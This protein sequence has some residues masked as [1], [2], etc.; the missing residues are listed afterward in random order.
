[1]ERARPSRLPLKSGKN[2]RRT[3]APRKRSARPERASR[4]ERPTR[5]RESDET[6]PP[7]FAVRRE[8]LAIGLLVA[9]L[10]T[11][12]ALAS[13]DPR[14]GDN[15]IGPAG[16]LAAL[17]LYRGFGVGAFALP[18]TLILGFMAAVRPEEKRI[19]LPSALSW[20]SLVVLASMLMEL[21]APDLRPFGATPGG[22]VGRLF[23]GGMI[24]V[25]S[26]VGTG[27]LIVAGM[28]A[29]LVVAAELEFRRIARF[30]G[31]TVKR[32]AAWIAAA[33]AAQVEQHRAEREARLAEQA[34]AE[35]EAIAEEEALAA[36]AFETALELAAEGEEKPGK[37][38][39]RKEKE[40]AVVEADL[41]AR[42]LAPEDLPEPALPADPAWALATR[43][44]PAAAHP[45][46][47]VLASP[48]P[49]VIEAKVEKVEPPEIVTAPDEPGAVDPAE[50]SPAAIQ[51]LVKAGKLPAPVIE[52]PKTPKAKKADSPFELLSE[53]GFSLPPLSLLETAGDAPKAAIDE[54][55]LHATAEKLRQKLAD[56][57]IQGHVERIRPGPVVTMYEFKP[58]P[59]VKI[60]KIAGLSDDLAMALEALRVRIVAPIPGRGVVGIEV[61][62]Q[63]RETV[64][65]REILT[66]DSFRKSSS[67]LAMAVGKDIEGMPFVA[68][69]AKMPHLLIAGTT[70]SGK[71]VGINSMIMS[72]LFRATPEEVRFIMVDPKMLELSIYEGVPHLLLPVVTDP[73]KASLALRWAVEEMERRYSLLAENGVRDILGFNKLVAEKGKGEA[74][75]EKKPSRK[76]LVIDVENGETEEEAVARMEAAADA[77]AEEAPPAELRKLPYV[78]IIIDELADLMM[79]ASKEVETYIARIAQ[80][81]R[82][83]GIH[84]M[85]A[86]QRPSVDVVTGIIKANFPSRV[87]FLLRSR[88]DSSTI[89]DT[90]GAEKLLGQGDML[91]LP[92]TSSHIQRV[93]GALVTEKEIKKVVDHLKAQGKPV[94]DESILRAPEEDGGSA[95][96][97]DDLPDELYDQA[98]AIVS[99]MRTVS[100]SILQRKMRIGYNRSARM[101]ERM[102]RDGLVGAADGMKPREVLV[103]GIGTMPN[104]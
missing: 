65:L 34:D 35:A 72:L 47:P 37:K 51:A 21:L 13:H 89:L 86:T 55:A 15:L 79:V 67:K 59:G 103:H 100:I 78:V 49:V 7:P 60:S 10:A 66:Q 4:P 11:G 27:I 88:V 25:F 56:F 87:S 6:P 92:P 40:E 31:T 94:Y 32:L 91:I 45:A 98:V 43:P 54:A 1:M 41:D 73:K 80:K 101:I 84:L 96:L 74:A 14:T 46:G 81:A 50:L 61:P 70:G 12:L 9:G 62:N 33:V 52:V 102:E 2:V 83:A 104:T 8:I 17:G 82:A 85:V 76:I 93:H 29:A 97:E 24:S 68:D 57:Q 26:R 71:S 95:A 69:L 48:A 3:A 58:A 75:P 23:T 20:L 19:G 18:L 39:K 36:A 16:N 64:Y 42:V 38:K 53:G 77:P 90:P 28:L 63:I 44:R 30:V 99:D 22:W 5:R